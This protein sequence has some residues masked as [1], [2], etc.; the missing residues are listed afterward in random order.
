VAAPKKKKLELK[1]NE[2]ILY[3]QNYTEETYNPLIVTTMR[4]MYS[5]DEK[6]KELDAAKIGTVAKGFHKKYLMV[7]LIMGLLAAPFL[8]IGGLK[9][10]NYRDK[11]TEPPKVVKGQKQKPLTQNDMAELAN[12]KTQKIVAIVLIAFGGAFGGVAYLLYKRRLTVIVA[13]SGRILELPMKNAMLQDQVIMMVNAAVTSA[14]AMA[15]PPMPEKVQKLASAP[16]KL[17]K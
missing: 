15:P 13:G 8:V 10:L 16:P 4:V 3:P 9:W 11:P 5:G 1:P 12:N 7:M 6:K 17:G 2:Q 14:K